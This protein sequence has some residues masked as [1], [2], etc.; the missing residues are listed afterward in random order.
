MSEPGLAGR[1]VIGVD[2][3]TG[4]VKVA[5]ATVR[6]EILGHEAEKTATSAAAGRRGRAGPGRLVAGPSSQRRGG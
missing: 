2:L 6:G 3:G 4:G 5:L 1:Y